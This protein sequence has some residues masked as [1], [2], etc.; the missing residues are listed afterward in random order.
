[1][2]NQWESLSEKDTYLPKYS[3]QTRSPIIKNIPKEASTAY[4]FFI[5]FFND[6]VLEEIAT[7]TNKYA[8][9]KKDK[10]MNSISNNDDDDVDNNEGERSKNL[11]TSTKWTNTCKNEIGQFLS[12]YSII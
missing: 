7:N 9:H 2:E 3:I 8:N 12:N 6:T 1:M 5:L 11:K 10:Y 4:D